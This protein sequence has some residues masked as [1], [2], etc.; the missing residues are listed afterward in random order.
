MSGIKVGPIAGIPSDTGTL[1][2]VD[3][4]AVAVFRVEDVV[5]A[6][7]DRCSHAEA[8]LSEG[9]VFD[10]EVEC[11]KHGA[12]FD[13]ATGAAL[14]LPATQPVQTYTTEVR[15]GDLYINS[16]RSEDAR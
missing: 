9:D 16:K 8:S 11:P 15:D 3:G 4:T 13:I 1:V 2:D 14:T 5:Y 7:D 10:G 12:A 6:I